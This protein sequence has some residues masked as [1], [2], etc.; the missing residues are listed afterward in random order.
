MIIEYPYMNC[1]CDKCQ[2]CVFIENEPRC[3]V[4]RLEMSDANARR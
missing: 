3:R 1:Y 2:N 4:I